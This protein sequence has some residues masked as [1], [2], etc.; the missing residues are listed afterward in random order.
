MDPESESELKEDC[1]DA[2]YGNLPQ[3]LFSTFQLA[4]LGQYDSGMFEDSEYMYLASFL[5]ILAVV[6]VLV[7]ALN[8]LIAL[9]GDSY[10]RVQE[11]AT[12]NQ[13]KER[14]EVRRNFSLGLVHLP[15]LLGLTIT[16]RFLFTAHCGIPVTASNIEERENRKEY[17]ILSR[18]TGS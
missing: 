8:A 1:N 12:A 5:F 15:R 4:L 7:V 11:K 6:V 14:A 2:P 18:F 10:S 13:R 9:L 3:A 17:I 16:C